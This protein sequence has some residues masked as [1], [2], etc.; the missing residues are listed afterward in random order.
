MAP[1]KPTI[2]ESEELKR[3]RKRSDHLDVLKR[4]NEEASHLEDQYEEA[5]A[6]AA[7]KKKSWDKVC[8]DIRVLLRK[9][10][11]PQGQL[12]FAKKD[13]DWQTV[14]IGNALKLTNKQLEKFESIKVKT[15]GQFENLRAGKHPDYPKGLSAVKGIGE[16]A[17]TK[18]ENE[19]L[20]WLEKFQKNGGKLD[21]QKADPKSKDEKKQPAWGKKPLAV[22][23]LSEPVSK[24]LIS[25]EITNV[26]RLAL[27]L[28]N[29]KNIDGISE[30]A[31]LTIRKKFD[32]YFKNEKLDNPLEKS[33]AK[34]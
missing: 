18:W 21:K 31:N 10:P 15:V 12:P 30:A 28:D 7:A 26:S 16:A 24:K 11:D 4:M 22:L 29:P 5:K 6:D 34:K 1:K 27:W 9:G 33:K 32:A 14:P 3:L 13:E 25:A 17:I 19:I 2:K 23:K 20:D 8:A